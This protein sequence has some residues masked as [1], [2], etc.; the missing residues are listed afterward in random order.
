MAGLNTA[1]FNDQMPN[2]SRDGLEIVFASD[3]TGGAGLFDI[4][5]STPSVHRGRLG[6]AGESWPVGQYDRGGD[7]PVP[8]GRWRAPSLRKARRHLGEHTQSDHGLRLIVQ[9]SPAGV[10]GAAGSPR[11][12]RRAEQLFRP[13]TLCL[14]AMLVAGLVED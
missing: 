3:R 14:P 1:G 7:A 5:V 11:E 12:L 10:A 13:A 2:V 9:P 8:L 6:G 4:Y